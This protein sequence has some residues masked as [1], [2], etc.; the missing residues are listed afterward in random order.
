MTR[1]LVL[2]LLLSSLLSAQ[3]RKTFE[4]ADVHASAPGT[5]SSGGF[6][7]G[8]RLEIH[9]V[10]M[11][12]LVSIA[13]DTETDYVFGGPSWLTS[14]KFD[15]IAKAPA[16]KADESVLQEMLRN[17]LI[18]RFA[19][20][21]HKDK[22]DVPVFVLTVAKG[23]A[24]LQKAAK[25]GPPAITSP[26]TGQRGMNRLVCNSCGMSE[27]AD[28]LPDRATNYV[29]HPV[30]DETRL[31]G[32]YD[33]QLDWMGINVYRAAK[34]NPDGPE[35]VSVFNAV[36]KLGLKL[37]PQNRPMPVIVVDS[38]NE[39]PTP[40]PP[41]VTSKIPNFPTEF[42]VA[43]VRPAKTAPPAGT[44]PMGEARFTN[45]QLEI[46]GATFHG[47]LQFA[48]DTRP[49][50]ISGAEKWMQEDRFDVIAKTS[51]D[52]PETALQ[53]MMKSLL[54][55]RFKLATHTENQNMPVW[56]LLAGKQPK[57]KESDGKSRSECVIEN[58]DH[59]Y[60]V[61]TNTTM[62]QLAER[63]PARAAAYIQPPL[64][65][66]TELKG[67]YDFRVY[68]TPRAQLPQG[69]SSGEASVPVEDITVF[70]AF[71]KQAGLKIEQQ[72]HPI[73]MLVID[74]ADRTPAN[75]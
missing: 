3:T 42:E 27:L 12:E 21:T 22:R 18:D 45:G 14:D 44:G 16:G 68:W 30:V 41:E 25:E 19:L 26:S 57:L 28:L 39:T 56:V 8:G 33:F 13:F 2:M 55:A 49:E 62:A 32:T 65:D 23:G 15:I 5:S 72:K 60:F 6:I 9:A 4:I 75:Q 51:R 40:N 35:A 31:K 34:A 7:P 17:L 69:V 46:M 70:Q 38:V 47:L 1:S 37:E 52:I 71:D 29:N 66:L 20:A 50:R 10:T 53:S 64:L 11:V 58:S 54:A 59:R 67:A 61:C 73:A 48:F 36:E 63:L 43:E 74:H 24:K